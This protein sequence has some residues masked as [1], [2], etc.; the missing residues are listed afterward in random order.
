MGLALLL[1]SMGASQSF[2]PATTSAGPR[3]MPWVVLVAGSSGYQNY[4]H[5]ADTCHAY[6]VMINNGV[7]AAQIITMVFD[8]VA[9]N[10]GNPFADK[11]FNTID[12]SDVYAGC[13]I[14]YSGAE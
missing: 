9:N 13:K 2:A 10:E 4:R 6:R 11:L 5:Q 3:R 7:P 8:D 1:V 14:D 12:G